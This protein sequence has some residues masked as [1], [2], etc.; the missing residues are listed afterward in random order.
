MFDCVE[1]IETILNKTTNASLSSYNS[2]AFTVTI[3]LPYKL[4][5]SFVSSIATKI[6]HPSPTFVFQFYNIYQSVYTSSVKKK[7][8]FLAIT[9]KTR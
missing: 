8:S 1:H 5:L 7:F 2:T 4:S 3:D 6:Q 9:T